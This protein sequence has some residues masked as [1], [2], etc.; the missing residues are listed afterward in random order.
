MGSPFPRRL[1]SFSR[2]ILFDKHGTGPVRPHGRDANLDMQADDLRACSMRPDPKERYSSAIRRAGDSQRSSPH[3]TRRASLRWSSTIEA[4]GQWLGL[5]LRHLDED[6]EGSAGRTL[7][8]VGVRL[9]GRRSVKDEAPS[10]AGDCG[11]DQLRWPDRCVTLPRR[12]PLLRRGASTRD[13]RARRARQRASPDARALARSEDSPV[14]ADLA[15]RIPERRVCAFRGRTTCPTPAISRLSSARSAI[16]AVGPRQRGRIDRVL[17]TVPFTDIVGSTERAADFSDPA[18]PTLERHHEVV[19]AMIGRYRG[20][21]I[22]TA[23]DR[24][25]AKFDGPAR[26]VRCAQA[27][28]E[29]VQALGHPDSRRA[30]H[31]R[32]GAHQRRRPRHRRA[33]RSKGGSARRSLQVLVSQTVKDLVAG[34]GIV[35]E[36]AGEHEL[37]GVP[38]DGTFTG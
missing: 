5:S 13:R 32:G 26:G 18:W 11:V 12:R 9:I 10:H 19:R 1:S 23:G 38:T 21:E 16:R 15:Q 8:G 36:D 3:R 24:F 30:G 2:V 22:T 6:R 7:L 35:F 27:I 14:S 33:H 17:V 20:A 31:R 28:V 25:F 29:A 4:P 37:K 34:S